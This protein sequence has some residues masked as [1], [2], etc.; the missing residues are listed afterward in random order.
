MPDPLDHLLD[1]YNVATLNS[2]AVEAGLLSRKGPRGGKVELVNLMK[3]MFFT[4]ERVQAS[5]ARLDPRE[6][7]P[8]RGSGFEEGPAADVHRS[9]PFV[10]PLA[11]LRASGANARDDRCTTAAGCRGVQRLE[12]E[13]TRGVG[14]ASGARP[15]PA[16]HQSASQW[17]CESPLDRGSGRATHD[18]GYLGTSTR[19]SGTTIAPAMAITAGMAMAAPAH[20]S[21]SMGWPQRTRA[22]SCAGRAAGAR[23]NRRPLRTCREVCPACSSAC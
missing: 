15:V 17:V 3:R 4:Q 10:L 18:T 11:S 22:P 19:T 21:S 1:S 16:A 23:L 9:T 5:L 2:M 6:R 13:C 7:R 12:Q 8:D 14:P 20:P